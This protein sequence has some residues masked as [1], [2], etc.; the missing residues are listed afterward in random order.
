MGYTGQGS[1]FKCLS[2][3]GNKN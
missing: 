2:K 1:D 3:N